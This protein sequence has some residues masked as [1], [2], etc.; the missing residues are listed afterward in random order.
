MTGTRG[1]PEQR[2]RRRLAWDGECLVWTGWRAASGHGLMGLSGN[3]KIRPHRLMWELMRGLIPEGLC[4]CHRCDNPP[5][6]NIEHLFLGTVGDNNR[7][8]FAKGRHGGG[9]RIGER[10]QNNRLTADA[11]VEIRRLHAA[12]LSYPEIS[13]AVPKATITNVHLIVHGKTWRHL[14]PTDQAQL[15]RAAGAR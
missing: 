12:G 15:Q 10:N 1:T 2:L 3:V 14:L 4:V 7:D 5:C 6:C 9:A 8:M 13:Q 11:V